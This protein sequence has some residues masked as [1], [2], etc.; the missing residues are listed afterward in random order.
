MV[1][2]I[3]LKQSKV[4]KTCSYIN[5]VESWIIIW[6]GPLINLSWYK[7]CCEYFMN[8]IYTILLIFFFYLFFISAVGPI[9][10]LK[11]ENS[12]TYVGIEAILKVEWAWISEPW[13]RL[14]NIM[15]RFW[16]KWLYLTE[17]KNPLCVTSW[18]LTFKRKF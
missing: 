10:F 12:C 2:T 16:S 15:V 18:G 6:S 9:F 5:N 3:Y 8:P 17:K 11:K 14:V 1:L 13:R 7:E 4:R